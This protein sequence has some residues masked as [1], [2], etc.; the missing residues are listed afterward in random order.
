MVDAHEDE[1]SENVENQET[2]QRIAE[3]IMEP[4]LQKM[5]GR[6]RE[7]G[8]AQEV[9]SALAN[10]YGGLLVDMLGRK[11]AATFLQ[12]HAIHIVSVEEQPLTN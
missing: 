5:L 11:G 3:E 2:I 8:S 12:R 7:E 10:C 6:A 1:K 4:E 9:M